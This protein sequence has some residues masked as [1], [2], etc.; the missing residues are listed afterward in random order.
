MARWHQFVLALV[1]LTRL[2]LERLLPR[3]ILS[4]AKSSWAFPLVGAI[5]GAAASLTFLL[6]GPSLLHAALALALAVWLTGA[7]HEDGL[8]DFADGAGGRDRE[9]RLRIMRDSAIGSY[10]VIALILTSLIRVAAISVLS[11]WHL[12]AAAACGRTAIILVLGGLLPARPDGLGHA[13]GTPGARNVG[14][15][16]IIALL[17]LLLAGDGAMFAL[18]AG[19]LATAVTIRQARVWLGGH[20]GDV[21]GATS[22]L[23]ETAVLAAFALWI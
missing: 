14:M 21:L 6:P 4:L 10:G 18:I 19:L 8:A 13:A 3:H 22:V 15:V 7:L 16:S 20:T 11:P 17:F 5:V 1:F 2:P 12:I 23:T 9:D